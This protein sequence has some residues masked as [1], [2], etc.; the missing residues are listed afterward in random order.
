MQKNSQENFTTLFGKAYREIEPK[1]SVKPHFLQHCQPWQVSATQSTNDEVIAAINT[2]VEGAIDRSFNILRTRIDKFGVNQPNIQ[3]LKGTGRIQIEL[4]GVDNRRTA[5]RKLLQGMAKLEFWEVWKPEEFSPYFSQMSDY[6][7][8]QEAAG[9]LNLTT[10]KSQ[11]SNRNCRTTP[12]PPASDPLPRHTRLLT[13]IQLTGAAK[14][15]D[16]AKTEL[17][18]PIRWTLTKAA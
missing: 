10:P 17:L 5:V 15:A 4:P 11:C 14:T 6:L 8:K 16:T 9:K 12:I 7:A 18:K 13:L 2:E 3:R 1:W